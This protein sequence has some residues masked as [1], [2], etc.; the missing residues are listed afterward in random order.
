MNYRDLNTIIVKNRYLLSL[1]IE[2][3][4]RLYDVKIF[5][6]LNLKDIY[7]RLRIRKSDK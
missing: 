5:L 6:K 3:L 2:I 1:I 4:N 7:Y